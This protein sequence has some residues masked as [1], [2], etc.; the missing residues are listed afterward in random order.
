VVEVSWFVAVRMDNDGGGC[1]A[2]GQRRN[3]EEIDKRL[4]REPDNH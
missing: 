3:D 4:E 1:A 2:S